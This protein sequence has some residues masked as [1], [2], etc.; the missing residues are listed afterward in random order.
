[1]LVVANHT[2][3]SLKILPFCAELNDKI[4]VIK[5]NE[6]PPGHC[7]ELYK[8]LNGNDTIKG[9]PITTYNNIST[10]TK[11]KLN[12]QIASF[13]A[14]SMSNRNSFTCP[15]KIQPT[16]R[17]CLNVPNENESFSI[18]VSIVKQDEQFFVSIFND[19]NPVLSVKNNTDFNIFV[20]Q[21]DMRN[22]NVKYIL[23]H[24]EIG[25]EKWLS[26]F[27]VV[28][29][30][31]KVFYTPPSLTEHFPEIV[32]LNYGIIFACVTGDQFIR[33][34][35]PIKIFETKKLIINLPLFGDLKVHV[36]TKSKTTEININYINS[37]EEDDVY[38]SITFQLL[39][40][41]IIFLF[42]SV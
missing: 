8:N 37:D 3:K 15:I 9:N 10:E 26:W 30:K 38:V 22:P 24:R 2:C 35:L 27:Q 39:K 31:K 32:N 20:A 14:I 5:R 1:M 28:P 25:E 40:L 11:H 18:N 36:D 41:V 33:W 12:S 21:T 23:P 16:L 19:S 34:S 7:V 13:F 42:F 17:K 6:I 29:S 4:E